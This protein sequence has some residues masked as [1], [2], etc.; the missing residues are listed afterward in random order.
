MPSTKKC[1]ELVFWPNQ[2]D[3]DIIVLDPLL[4]DHIGSLNIVICIP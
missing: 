4:K 3:L 2:T 1:E